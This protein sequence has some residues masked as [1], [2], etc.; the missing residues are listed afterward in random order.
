MK[1]T[2]KTK[3]SELQ[4]IKAEIHRLRAKLYHLSVCYKIKHNP[5]LTFEECLCDECLSLCVFYGFNGEE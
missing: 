1:D 5:E 4:K 2:R 3:G